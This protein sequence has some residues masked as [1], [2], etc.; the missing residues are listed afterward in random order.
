MA[1]LLA[2][3]NVPG[4]LVEVL[5]AHGHN[6]WWARTEARGSADEVLLAL[7]QAQARVVLTMDKD[8]G[9]LA[10]RERLPA[11]HGVV[12]LRLG[13]LRLRRLVPIVLEA[14][15][16]G[17]AQHGKFTVVEEERLRMVPLP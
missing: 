12:L 9:V 8:F 4:G 14:L 1:R 16:R 2:D 11:S 10:F 17:A 5:R 3:E 6:V 7:A 15:D 13:H